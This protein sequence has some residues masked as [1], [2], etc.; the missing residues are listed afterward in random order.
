MAFYRL[1]NALL[2]TLTQNEEI[3]AQPALGE[4]WIAGDELAYVGPSLTGDLIQQQRAKT[5]AKS[6]LDPESLVAIDCEGALLMPGFKNAHSHAAMTFLRNAA[7]DLPVL[8]WLQNLVFPLEAKLTPEQVRPFIQLAFLEYLSSGITACCDMYMFPDVAAELATEMGFRL[9]LCGSVNDFVSSPEELAQHHEH[10]NKMHP[11]VSHVLGCHAEYTCSPKLLEALGEVVAHYRAPF[12]THNSESAAEVQ[13]CLDRHQLTPTAWL[14][15]H[16]LLDYGGAFYHAVHLSENDIQLCLEHDIKIVH[17]PSA[18]CKLSS[19]IAPICRYMEAGLTVAL[20]TDGPASNNALDFF[21][22]M[23]LATQLQK[24][25]TLNPAAL[26][27]SEVLRFATSHAAQ[28]MDLKNVGELQVGQAADLILIDL[29]QPNL[30]PLLHL[31]NSLVYSGNK[32]NIMMTMIAGEIRYWQG[33]YRVGLEPAAV[34]RDVA[35]RCQ[36]LGLP[37]LTL[38]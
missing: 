32:Q 20:G 25:S 31:P 2:L 1:F 36:E 16:G 6:K 4:V 29:A 14:A 3:P 27:P 30:Q 12:F 34:Y 21:R 9:V 7:D 28:A 11:L 33:E 5:A 22:E 8:D 18:N 10:F 13:S 17:N 37:A 15:K 26:P 19:G 24:V 38:G 23:N 35:A